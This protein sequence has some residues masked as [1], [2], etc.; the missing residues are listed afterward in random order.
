MVVLDLQ[1]TL[2]TVMCNYVV[3]SGSSSLSIFTLHWGICTFI[4]QIQFLL[5]V[6]H[7]AIAVLCHLNNH[8]YSSPNYSRPHHS[9]PNFCNLNTLF[10]E[11]PFCRLTLSKMCSYPFAPTMWNQLRE[12]EHVVKCPSLPAFKTSKPTTSCIQVS[13]GFIHLVS[14]CF[15]S[16]AAFF[17]LFSF[18]GCVGHPFNSVFVHY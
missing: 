13:L 7:S 15:P 10:L 16:L 2:T 3:S 12:H 8:M 14:L 18:F 17:F 11:L 5:F 9:R 1:Q 4:S 6:K